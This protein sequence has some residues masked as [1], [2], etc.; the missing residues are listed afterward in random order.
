M[1]K[2]SSMRARVQGD[3][4]ALKSF[5]FG[6][7]KLPLKRRRQISQLQIVFPPNKTVQRI[8]Q[9]AR[10]RIENGLFIIKPMRLKVFLSC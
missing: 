1:Y 2:S 5:V 3:D 6:I 9:L 10:Q 8:P 4:D 7:L